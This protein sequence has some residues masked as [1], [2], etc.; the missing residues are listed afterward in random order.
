MQKISRTYFEPRA[1]DPLI[2]EGLIRQADLIKVFQE[3][4]DGDLSLETLLL[5]KYKIPTAR[6][7][8]ALSEFFDCPYV[9][10][11]DRIIVDP[12]LLKDLSRDYLR[13]HHWIPF[14]R[15]D[16]VLDILIDNPH[17]LDRG[18]DIRRAFPGIAFQVQKNFLPTGRPRYKNVRTWRFADRRPPSAGP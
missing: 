11:D 15:Q 8:N 4:L 3:A 7:G 6:L 14:K 17:D 12:A 2:A 18:G 13:N 16:Q 1:L 9:P 5:D 10:Y